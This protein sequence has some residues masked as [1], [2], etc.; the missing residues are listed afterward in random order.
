MFISVLLPEPLS[1]HQR[2]ELAALDGERDALEHGHVDLAE[3]VG[4]ADVFELDEFHGVAESMPGTVGAMPAVATMSRDP[5]TRTSAT[6]ATTA[7]T[8]AAARER[9]HCGGPK[10]LV[11]PAAAALVA[12]DLAGDDFH[13][14]A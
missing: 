5:P 14:F 3:V 10:G 12:G 6:A 2:D 13:A 7:A 4:L 1:A 9:P 8:A 11:L